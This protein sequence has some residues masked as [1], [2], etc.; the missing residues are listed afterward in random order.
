[1]RKTKCLVCL[2]IDTDGFI[3]FFQA[4]Q[5]YENLQF[6]KNFLRLFNEIEFL[7]SLNSDWLDYTTQREIISLCTVNE[8][9]SRGYMILFQALNE[10][11]IFFSLFPYLLDTKPIFT[12]FDLIYKKISQFFDKTQDTLDLNTLYKLI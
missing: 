5:N 9:L 6:K 4:K 2:I 12:E 10:D 3:I 7:S 11:L 8:Y 1:M